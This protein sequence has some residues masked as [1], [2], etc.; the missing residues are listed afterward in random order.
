LGPVVGC[1]EHGSEPSGCIN[2]R[3]FLE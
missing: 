1:Y 3:Q 2:G